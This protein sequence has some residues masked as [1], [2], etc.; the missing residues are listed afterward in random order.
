MRI[1]DPS[2]YDAQLPGELQFSRSVLKQ[3][4]GLHGDYFIE[5]VVSFA[6]FVHSLECKANKSDL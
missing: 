5:D 2:A 6:S 1:W 4:N 3:R